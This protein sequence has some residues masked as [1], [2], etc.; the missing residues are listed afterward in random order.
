LAG[1]SFFCRDLEKLLDCYLRDS[2]DH[3]D[4]QVTSPPTT[5]P[6]LGSDTNSMGKIKT[7]K[8]AGGA[9]TGPYDRKPAAKGASN[10]NIFK[11][12]KDFGQHILKNPGIRLEISAGP[13]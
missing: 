5:P 4:T 3:A 2:H 11:F 1:L 8:R 7:P 9:G 12:D 13:L 6:R 10:T